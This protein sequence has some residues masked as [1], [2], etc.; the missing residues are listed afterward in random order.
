MKLNKFLLTASLL[1]G[2]LCANA[3]EEVTEYVYVPNWYIQAQVGMQETLGEGSFESLLQPN[4]QLAG[5]YNFNPYVGAR[6]VLN[7][8]S[9]KGTSFVQNTRYKWRWNYVAPTVNAVFNMTNILGGYNPNRIVEVDVF[10]GIGVN[11]GF[12]NDQAKDAN[13]AFL[14]KN[15]FADV[16]E[17]Y[18]L[19][20]LWDGT[21]ARF[22]GQFGADVNFN[23]AENWQVG[24]ELQ[25]NVLPDGYN[26]KKAGN[27]D[28]YFNFLVGAKYTF[29]P[30]YEK[31]VKTVD[32]VPCEPQI[33]EKIVEKIVEVP[34]QVQP[35]V[36]KVEPMRRDV[37]F[38]ISKTVITADEMTKVAAIADYMKAN[39]N[40]KVVITGYADKGTGSLALNLRLSAKRAQVVADALANKYGIERSRMTVKSMGEEESQPYNDPVQNRVAIMIAE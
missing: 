19:Q 4:V 27:A 6:L 7:A 1:L 2:G 10:A 20:N 21:K 13:N 39:P 35:E 33:V 40:S 38:K 25:A 8:W 9:S 5:G 28:W 34:V 12:G 29:G 15:G 22:L 17:N 3:Q 18:M 16:R 23:V 24:L 26:S 31:R 30:S 14:N 11:I 36:K 37:F 32:A